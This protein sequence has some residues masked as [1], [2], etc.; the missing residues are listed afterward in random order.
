MKSFLIPTVIG[1]L[2]A[3]S[4][5]AQTELLLSIRADEDVVVLG[6][7][8]NYTISAELLNPTGPILATIVDFGFDLTFGSPNLTITNNE[9]TSSFDSDFFGPADDGTVTGDTILDAHGQNGIP[10]FNSSGGPDSSNPIEIYNFTLTQTTPDT[11]LYFP[12]F[13]LNG[14]ISG[15]YENSPLPIV[16]YYQDANGN[17][18]SVPVRVVADSVVFVPAPASGLALLG[19]GTIA[20]RR[21]R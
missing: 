16:F 12:T 19:L 10:P 14:Q 18:G 2:C 15:S 7:S 5:A 8:V 6:G 9:F 4:A 11:A 13:V 21:R 20:T 17:P 3:G 1:S